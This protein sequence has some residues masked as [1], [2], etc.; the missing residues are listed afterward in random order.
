MCSQSSVSRPNAFSRR[1]D[2]DGNQIQN[3]ILL[4]LPAKE[5]QNLVSSLEFVRLSPRQV[6]HETG[7]TLKSVYFCNS[8]MFSIMA[9]L[10]DGKSVEV[11]LTGREGFS[12]VPLIAGFRTSNTRTVVQVEATAF[13]LDADQFRDAPRRSPSFAEEV[14]RYGQL[15][16]MQAAQIA[17]CNRFHEVE[18]R[19]ARWLLM[20]EDCLGSS[21]L[22]LTQVFLAQMLGSRRSSVSLAAS[23]LRRSGLIEYTKG[24]T[25]ILSREGLIDASCDCYEQLKR[26][27][28]EWMSQSD[29]VF[30]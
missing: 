10:P 3:Q 5:F 23:T 18:E 30:R 17:A 15:V 21:V 29:G 9:V 6:L 20:C 7:A 8:G 2:A 28:E 14:R 24:S 27:G 25:T 19:L 4:D 1:Q 26:Q 11:G 22:P 13:R 12:G 16:A